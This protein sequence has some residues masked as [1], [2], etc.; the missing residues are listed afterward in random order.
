LGDQEAKMMIKALRYIR[1]SKRIFRSALAG[2]GMASTSFSFAHS[3][4]QVIAVEFGIAPERDYPMNGR[5]SCV[6]G[7]PCKLLETNDLQLSVSMEISKNGDQATMFIDC[8]T[9]P[10]SF[11]NGRSTIEIGNKREFDFYKGSVVGIERLLVM[12]PEVKIGRLLL[13]YP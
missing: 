10:C 12:K 6:V 4:P 7:E 1:S 5:V 3:M 9:T 13:L 2:L 11:S 8:G